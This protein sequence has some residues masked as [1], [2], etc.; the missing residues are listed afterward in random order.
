M[1]DAHD[2]NKL[3][4]ERAFQDKVITKEEYVN[5][6]RVETIN[7]NDILNAIDKYNKIFNENLFRY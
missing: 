6:V 5:L 7:Y 1:K 3:T 4:I 2:C